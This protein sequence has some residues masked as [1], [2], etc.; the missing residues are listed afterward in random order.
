MVISEGE[1]TGVQREQMLVEPDG[2]RPA[3]FRTG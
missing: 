1:V 3:S 2:G